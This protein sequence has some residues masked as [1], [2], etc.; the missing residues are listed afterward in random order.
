M[1]IPKDA[2][3][4]DGK[5]LFVRVKFSGID[6]LCLMIDGETQYTFGKGESAVRYLK[7]TQAIEWHK[8]EILNGNPDEIHPKMV[9][10]LQRIFDYQMEDIRK[11]EAA[12]ASR[13]PAGNE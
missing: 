1:A 7:M 5:D 6:P 11:E 10:G 3:A 13:N 12:G 4:Y 9:E 8:R 2:V